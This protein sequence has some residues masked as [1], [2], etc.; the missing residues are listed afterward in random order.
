MVY[1]AVSPD[2]R[3][4]TRRQSTTSLAFSWGHV[5]QHGLPAVLCLPRT[6]RKCPECYFWNCKPVLVSRWIYSIESWGRK[7]ACDLWTQFFLL[8]YLPRGRQAFSVKVQ[9]IYLLDFGQHCMYCSCHVEATERLGSILFTKVY[10]GLNWAPVTYHT[11]LFWL[12]LCV[13][14]CMYTHLC[15][16]GE[17]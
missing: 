2:V 4:E 12:I 16:C 11:L 8:P 13:R 3:A 7:V 5:V 6:E 15:A 10:F 9:I 14:V 1:R 17:C